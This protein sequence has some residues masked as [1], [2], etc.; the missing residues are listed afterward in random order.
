MTPLRFHRFIGLATSI[1]LLLRRNIGMLRADCAAPRG[2]RERFHT[3]IGV[4]SS[5]LFRLDIGTQCNKASD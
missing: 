2:I 1:L 5:A 4:Y 3:T